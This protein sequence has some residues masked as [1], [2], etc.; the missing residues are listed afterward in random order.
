M[1]S[2]I[3]YRLSKDPNN[4]HA[5]WSG[6]VTVDTKLSTAQARRVIAKHL[7]LEKLPPNTLVLSDHDLER[8]QWTEAEIRAE[9]SKVAATD[10]RE[11]KKH[12]K[13]SDVPLNMDDVKAMLKKFGLA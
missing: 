3:H 5:L 8:G 11:A 2:R 10:R 4:G 6:A 9:T 7:R 12:V 13:V 1:T